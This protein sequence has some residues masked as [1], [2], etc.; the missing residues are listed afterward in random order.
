MRK[1]IKKPMTDYALKLLI[2]RLESF[3]TDPKAQV[4]ILKKSIRNN[5]QDI[6]DLKDEQ[7][8]SQPKRAQASGNPFL[9]LARDENIF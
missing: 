5:W 4:E 9:D 7:Q 8:L 3:T 1:L 6:Y 2:N